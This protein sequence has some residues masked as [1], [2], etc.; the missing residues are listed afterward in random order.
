LVVVVKVAA[1]VGTEAMKAEA[2]A[3]A[4]AHLPECLS[5]LNH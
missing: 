1:G 2:V 4:V 3:E 5:L